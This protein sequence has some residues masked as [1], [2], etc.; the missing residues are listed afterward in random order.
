MLFCAEMIEALEVGKQFGRGRPGRRVDALQAVSLHVARGEIVAIVGPNGAG[1]STLLGLVLGFLRATAGIITVAAAAPRSYVRR[2]G[3]A[4]LPER[5]TLPAEWPVLQTLLSLARLEGATRADAAARARVALVRFG[6][7]DYAAR[8]IGTL[9]RGLLQRVGLAQATLAPHALVVLDEPTEGLDPRG[10]LLFRE[11]LLELRAR[12]ATVL[13][14][15]HDLAELERIADRAIVLAGGRVRE[16][17]ELGRAPAATMWSLRLAA[18]HPALAEAFP[19]AEALEG[20]AHWRIRAADEAELNARL[21]AL[22]AAGALVIELTPAAPS[23]EERVREVLAAPDVDA[24]TG[25]TA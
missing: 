3:A 7:E 24:A 18:P 20:I 15:S 5:F 16:T 21:A 4:F 25:E 6:L 22:L 11:L 17:L 13:L 19:H 23:L 2:H 10:R 8:P 1:K 12:A 9:S 14:S